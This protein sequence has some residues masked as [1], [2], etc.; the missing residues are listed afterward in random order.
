MQR[1]SH[2]G[3]YFNLMGV[4]LQF[5]E[6]DAG[7]SFFQP[8]SNQGVIHT[9]RTRPHLVQ[10]HQLHAQGHLLGAQPSDGRKLLEIL[11]NLMRL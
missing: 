5:A 2:C 9:P 7:P 6:D 8:P 1:R 11:M 3:V 4:S 10:Q